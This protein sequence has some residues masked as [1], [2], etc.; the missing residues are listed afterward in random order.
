MLN[1]PL[2]LRALA[3]TAHLRAP[4]D[5]EERWDFEMWVSLAKGDNRGREERRDSADAG[6]REVRI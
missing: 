1:N 4:P 5:A 2:N 3:N 6:G